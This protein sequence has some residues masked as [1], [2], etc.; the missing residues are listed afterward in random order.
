MTQKQWA[1]EDRIDVVTSGCD[2]GVTIRQLCEAHGISRRTY[3]RWKRDVLGAVPRLTSGTQVQMKTYAKD[4]EA[5]KYRAINFPHSSLTMLNEVGYHLCCSIDGVRTVGELADLL[6]E[7]YP[8]AEPSRV[9]RDTV[10]FVAKLRRHKLIY[11]AGEYPPPFLET[12]SAFHPQEIWLNVTNACNL[13]CITCFKAA[14]T[15]YRNEMSLDM[16]RD[17]I[18]Q[19][20]ELGV[21]YVV[22]SGGEPFIRRDTLDV[23][24]YLVERDIRAHVITNGTLI[25]DRTAIRLGEIRPW[26]VQVSLDG[27]CPEVNDRIRG[28]GAFEKTLRGAK[29]LVAQDLD[30]RLY[31]TVNKLNIHDLGNIKKLVQELR[32]GFNHLGF[33]KF[34]ATGR[35]KEHGAELDIPE[36][37][38]YDLV[39]QQPMDTGYVDEEQ[40]AELERGDVTSLLPT[41]TAYGVRKIN[42]GFGSGTFSIDADGNVYPC[43]WLHA[44][45]WKAGNLYEHSLSEI[46]HGSA[47]FQRCRNIRVDHDIAGCR[48]CDYKYFCGGGCR[49]RAMTKGDGLHSCDPGCAWMSRYYELGFWTD[50]RWGQS[51]RAVAAA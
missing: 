4:G 13:R 22:V 20:A 15:C 34:Y 5:P 51:D 26:R 46:Y 23:I 50:F 17:V 16:L 7:R 29:L 41:R 1:S 25:D 14:G 42:C 40:A 44:E 18:D 48:S 27:S 21:D 28:E 2:P 12:T 24:A 45:E 31:P 3:Q 8:E 10:G 9:V 6:H 19:I 11:L 43:H 39:M 30:V 36:E 49:A 38:F 33:A 37:E 47:V 35:G 32:P